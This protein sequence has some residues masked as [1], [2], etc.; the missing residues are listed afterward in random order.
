MNKKLLNITNKI[1][2]RSADSRNKYLELMN[3]MQQNNPPRHHLSC[4]NL[5]HAIAGCSHDDKTTLKNEKTINL[6]II[7]SY[8][9]MLSAHKTYE[10][11]PEI[12]RNEANFYNATAQVA[13][14]VPAMCDGVTQGQPGMELSLFSRDIIAL[15]TTIGLSHNMFDGAMFLGICDKIVPGMLIGALKFGHLPSIFVPGGPMTSGISNEEK[16]KIRND[17]TLSKISKSE[18][19]DGELSSYHSNGTCTFYGTAN[20]NQMLMEIMGLHLPGSSFVPANSILRLILTKKAVQQVIK[21]ANQKQGFLYQIVNEKTIVNG[22]VGLLSSGGSTNLLIHIIAIAAS[23][24]IIIT[25][26]DISEISSITPLITK[27]Y[28]NGKADINEFHENGGVQFLISTLLKNG[29][30]HENV[31]TVI[32]NSLK[33]YTKSP[34]LK[35]DKLIWSH[36]AFKAVNDEILRPVNK[37]F[38]KDGGLKVLKGNLG[39]SVIKTSSVKPE[40]RIIKAPVIIFTEKDSFINAFQKGELNKN[41]IIVMKYQGPKF[42]GMPELHYLTPMLTI[43]QNR[44]FKVALI[45]DGRMSGASGNVP[46]AIHL[47]PEA[48]DNGSIGKL[49]DGDIIELNSNTGTLNV[50]VD[51]TEFN[52]R[53]PSHPVSN[54]LGVGRELFNKIRDNINSSDKGATFLNF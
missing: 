52:N 20:T 8:N 42:N 1:R 44:G 46:A 19:L 50:L 34:L 51:E 40:N 28:P 54:N 5:A 17:F 23:A 6:G 53:I 13:A 11:Y 14:G 33:D 15:S 49:I 26:E 45:T 10:N 27:V 4:G 36:S 35:N 47:S 7:N 29:L 3:D 9:D 22:I 31:T 38:D 18:L 32:G 48:I 2:E 30:L 41:V 39:I 21:N 16:A 24:G 12:I 37:P 25:L 43:I